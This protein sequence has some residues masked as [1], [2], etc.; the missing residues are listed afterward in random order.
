MIF[1]QYRPYSPV[2]KLLENISRF[3]KIQNDREHKNKAFVS[4]PSLSLSLSRDGSSIR[5]RGDK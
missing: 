3:F 1:W 4:T 5:P 2:D